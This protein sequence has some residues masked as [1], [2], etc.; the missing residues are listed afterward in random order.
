VVT[1]SL[2]KLSNCPVTHPLAD[3]ANRELC[4][5]FKYAKERDDIGVTEA[6]PNYSFSAK[7]LS[8]ASGYHVN[9]SEYIRTAFVFGTSSM[10]VLIDLRATTKLPLLP[11]YTSENGDR[12]TGFGLSRSNVYGKS[13]EGGRLSVRRQSVRS[14]LMARP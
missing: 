11:R 3:K 9:I 4:G 8:D 10:W 2:Q 1:I 6:S 7:C 13:N 5:W 12:S 14:L